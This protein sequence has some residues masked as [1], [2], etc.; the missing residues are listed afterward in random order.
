MGGPLDLRIME[1]EKKFDYSFMVL[2]EG[3][4]AESNEIPD[5]IIYQIQ[6]FS[7]TRK[8]DVAALKGLSPVFERRN[9]S[10]RYIY[11]VGL[12]NTYNDVVS[13]LNT[14]K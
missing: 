14:V 11:R 6:M 3:Q 13:K 7:S 1:P 10:G 5:G 9:A 12:F 8:A 4:F 2:D